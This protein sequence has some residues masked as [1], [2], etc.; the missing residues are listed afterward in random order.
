MSAIMAGLTLTTAAQSTEAGEEVL[1]T[2]TYNSMTYFSPDGRFAYQ[3]GGGSGYIYAFDSGK[4]YTFDNGQVEWMSETGIGVGMYNQVAGYWTEKDGW[5]ELPAGKDSDKKSSGVYVI[6]PDGRIIVGKLQNHGMNEMFGDVA[7]RVPVIWEMKDDGTYGEYEILPTFSKCYDGRNPQGFDVLDI[8]DD[9]STLLGRYVDCSGKLMLPIVYRKDS[10]GQWQMTMYCED[11]CVDKSQPVPTFPDYEPQK[12]V[13]TDYYNDAELAAFNEA[14]KLYNDSLYYAQ[15]DWSPDVHPWPNYIPEDHYEDFFDLSTEDGV[16]RHNAY[17]EAYNKYVEEAKVYNDQLAEYATRFDRYLR[18]RTQR[19][20]LGSVSSIRISPNG[21]WAIAQTV[22]VFTDED[23]G[24]STQYK[25]PACINLENGEMWIPEIDDP[26]ANCSMGGV[27]DNGTIWTYN[28]VAGV[29]YV[30]ENGSSEI[31]SLDDFISSK[32]Q[33]AYDKLTQTLQ[34]YGIFALGHT[35]MLNGD[36]T[37]MHGFVRQ[38]GIGC[39]NYF[40]DLASFPDHSTVAKHK[41]DKLSFTLHDREL[42]INGI[43]KLDIRIYN[44]HGQATLTCTR[45][46]G[47]ISLDGLSNGVYIL[48]IQGEGAVLN[49]KIVLR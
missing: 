3:G 1:N 13:G 28:E 9:G 39:L 47:T 41:A 27:S 35:L 19:F 8:S 33:Q 34:N 2:L 7:Q 45:Q 20:D 42:T 29:N 16:K 46:S 31:M 48:S 14:V 11:W 4:D 17:A 18:Y 22:Q 6:S 15:T 44:L 30:I 32:S 21:K 10:N 36:G 49:E 40:I 24:V 38:V 26:S 23:G 25:M 5:K 12:P 43:G 37:R